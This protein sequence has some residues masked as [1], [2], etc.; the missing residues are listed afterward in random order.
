MKRKEKNTETL[1]KKL[2]KQAPRQE[3]NPRLQELD[4]L[5]VITELDH[6]SQKLDKLLSARRA[7]FGAV[8][9]II[10]SLLCGMTFLLGIGLSLYL[11]NIL[12]KLQLIN[13]LFER[14]PSIYSMFSIF[15]H[16]K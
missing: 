9:R 1:L 5:N 4:E 10:V 11:L 2:K 14:F 3:R 13:F 8:G 16:I 15:V 6:I 7:L 12:Y